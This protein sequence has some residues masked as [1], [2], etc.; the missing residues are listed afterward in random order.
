DEP[1]SG[2]DPNQLIEIR[3]LISEIGKLKTVIMSTHVM[4]E[5]EALCNR[6][7]II[8][9][10]KIVADDTTQNLQHLATSRVVI[11]VEFH[12]PVKAAALQGISGVVQVKMDGSL[13]EQSNNRTI[14]Q[15]N[16]RSGRMTDLTQ[17]NFWQ[18]ISEPGVDIRAAVFQFA[19]DNKLTVLSLQREEQKLEEVFQELTRN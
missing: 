16:I 8:H 17:S 9:K 4:Q 15:S 5:V 7:I 19:V 18:L 11:N 1:T 3:S 6:A 13:Y 2:L 14:E 12:S 10:G